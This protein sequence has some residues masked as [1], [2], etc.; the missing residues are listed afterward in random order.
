MRGIQSV[1]RSPYPQ[2]RSASSLGRTA[3]CHAVP[4]ACERGVRDSMRFL[5]PGCGVPCLRPSHEACGSNGTGGSLP[6]NGAQNFQC[7]LPASLI[8]RPHSRAHD[9]QKPAEGER[10]ECTRYHKARSTVHQRNS[11]HE[12]HELRGTVRRITARYFQHRSG[13]SW[14]SFT[15]LA[16]GL[17]PA[18]R[19]S[20]CP[21]CLTGWT[22]VW[23]Q[24]PGL[25]IACAADWVYRQEIS[26]PRCICPGQGR[27]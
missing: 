8:L 24:A 1:H 22:V 6:P 26:R 25:W 16:G 19:P 9:H 17:L 14:A 12:P 2:V 15:A 20:Q 4:M 10:D 23:R 3:K 27:L 13:P 18:A 21:S 7:G 11:Q 5:P